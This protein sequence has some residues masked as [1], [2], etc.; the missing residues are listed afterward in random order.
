MTWKQDILEVAGMVVTWWIVD[1]LRSNSMLSSPAA[2]TSFC[3]LLYTR[4]WNISTETFVAF[5]QIHS[6]AVISVSEVCF[7][8]ATIDALG[9]FETG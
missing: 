7:V 8:V 5:H 3:N 1:F 9:P 2:I 6:V 4:Q